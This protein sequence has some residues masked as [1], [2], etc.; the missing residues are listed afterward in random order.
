MLA[1]DIAV[2][3]LGVWSAAGITP[4]QLWS[5]VMAAKPRGERRNFPGLPHP[6]A[7][8]V[9]PDPPPS[10]ALPQARR[11]DRAVR[12]A[13]AAATPAFAEARLN[14]LDPD[15]VA[16]LVGNSRGPVEEATHADPPR[17][18]P[19]RVAHSAVASLSGALSLA[20]RVRGPCLTV[21]ATCASS[22]HA[23]A[24]GAGLLRCGVV[25]AVLAGGAEAPLVPQLLVQFD[26]AH[27]L[28]HEAPPD[29]ACRPFAADRKGILPGEGAAFL[30]LERLDSALRRGL[31]PHARL[32]SALMGSESHNRVAAHPDGASLARQIER[33]LHESGLVP[34][35]IGYINAHGTGTVVNDAAEAA[36]FRRVFG[37]SLALGHP[38]VSSTKPVTGHTFGAAGALEAVIAILALRHRQA[39]PTASTRIPAPDLGI[40]PVL[41]S[42]VPLAT[43]HVLSTSLGFWGNHATLLF[44]R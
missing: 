32:A 35:D 12:L 23:I 27:L 22:A 33:A 10:S 42:P 6:C 40:P 9:A 38:A 44:S 3:G 36:A 25:D 4:D 20:F 5:S 43:P 7:V 21:S 14:E 15:R 13:L 31:E 16:I 2:T 37:P 28:D 1:P 39:P 30:V 11:M 29:A 8:C 18:R 24:L 17:P 41:G 19:T 34:A 26:A